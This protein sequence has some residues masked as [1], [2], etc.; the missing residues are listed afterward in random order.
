[1]L[2]WKPPKLPSAPRHF[3]YNF[4]CW[5]NLTNFPAWPSKTRPFIQQRN[6]NAIEIL[7]SINKN[8]S[9]Y[10]QKFAMWRN[11]RPLFEFSRLNSFILD[12][13]IF[14][15]NF[16]NIDIQTNKLIFWIFA[17]NLQTFQTCKLVFWIFALKFQVKHSFSESCLFIAFVTTWF[18]LFRMYWNVL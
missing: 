17:P 7:L 13:S 18:V 15:P 9:L 3:V 12:F 14:R 1:M 8:K 16:E 6:L 10:E 11:L 4:P 2:A 5:R